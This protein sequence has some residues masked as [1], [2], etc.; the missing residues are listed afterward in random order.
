MHINLTCY[1]R[2]GVVQQCLVAYTPR[3]S[4][5]EGSMPGMLSFFLSC[6]D[7]FISFFF[8]HRHRVWFHNR[9]PLGADTLIICIIPGMYFCIRSAVAATA[10][11]MLLLQLLPF[12]MVC[13][14]ANL[15]LWFTSS[16]F[17]VFFLFI[18][19]RVIFYVPLGSILSYLRPRFA[20]NTSSV[21]LGMRGAKAGVS[22]PR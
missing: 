18:Q 7:C 6:R 9:V 8:N 11:I 19:T 1:V 20:H 16:D 15:F 12:V 22:P 3:E 14:V 10:A 4:E 13:R 21:I 5:V 17:S 2:N